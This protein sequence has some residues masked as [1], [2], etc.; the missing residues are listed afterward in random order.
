MDIE[1]K[2]VVYIGGCGGI[3]S[4][5]C[6]LFAQ[7]KVANLAMLDLEENVNLV[8]DIKLNN[9]MT[10][11]FFLEIDL[12]S[13][14]N[15]SECLNKVVS[16]IGHIDI[17]VNGSGLFN[18][19]DA[20]LTIGVNLLGVINTTSIA[21]NLMDTLEDNHD[22]WTVVN[23][24]SVAGLNPIKTSPIYSASKAGLIAFTRSM[25][26]QSELKQS[27][28]SFITICPGLT[29]TNLLDQFT[30]ENKGHF[31]KL[32]TQLFSVTRKQTKNE[33]AQSIMKAIELNKNGAVYMCDVGEIEEIKIPEF[34]IP[35]IVNNI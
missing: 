14:E 29:K 34:W 12:R 19:M 20:D 4:T 22:G 23:I 11:V 6:K 33:C 8:N 24:A 17:L 9:P 16:R 21:M 2:N 25:A 31:A 28:I 7:K 30:S 18:E 5:L 3:G 32:T 35:K 15:I 26:E 1:G 27:G 13:K 10:I